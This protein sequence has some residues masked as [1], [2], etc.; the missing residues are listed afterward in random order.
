M[1]MTSPLLLFVTCIYLFNNHNFT[2]LPFFFSSHFVHADVF[3]CLPLL[4]LLVF[5]LLECE[6]CTRTRKNYCTVNWLLNVIYR[7][8]KKLL[9]P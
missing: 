2:F 5:F 7:K 4:H 1:A 9:F 3:I 6:L 8:L